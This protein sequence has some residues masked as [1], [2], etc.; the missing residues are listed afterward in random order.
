MPYLYCWSGSA[1]CTAPAQTGRHV[2]PS[3][4][5]HRT[6]N[7]SLRLTLVQACADHGTNGLSNGLFTQ[8]IHKYTII[9]LMHLSIVSNFATK[10]GKRNVGPMQWMH[11]FAAR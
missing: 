2:R 4:R 5:R 9:M 10:A 1:Q 11:K 3:L 6:R 7:G 8:D